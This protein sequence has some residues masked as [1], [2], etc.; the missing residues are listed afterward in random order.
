MS[1]E[2]PLHLSGPPSAPSLPVRRRQGREDVPTSLRCCSPDLLALVRVSSLQFRPLCLSQNERIVSLVFFSRFDGP[3]GF[4]VLSFHSPDP[5]LS[6]LLPA[7]PSLLPPSPPGPQPCEGSTH[8]CAS[9]CM[10]ARVCAQLGLW[11]FHVFAFPATDALTG[12]R[13][14]GSCRGS[15][16]TLCL[17]SPPGLSRGRGM[18]PL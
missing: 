13:V 14:W 5:P 6:S 17:L 1:L 7:P 8:T 9:V 12:A 10:C 2:E 3:P 11:S 15:Y 18:K 4:R 16:R